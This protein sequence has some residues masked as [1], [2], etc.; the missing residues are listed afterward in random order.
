MGK[1]RVTPPD[2]AKSINQ[3]PK[4]SEGYFVCVGVRESQKRHTR[5]IQD[6]VFF[7]FAFLYIAGEVHASEEACILA[8]RLR[9]CKYT[10]ML[11]V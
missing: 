1:Q 7:I 9:M 3:N 6:K 2:I 10:G 5:N 4:Q 11:L 8:K